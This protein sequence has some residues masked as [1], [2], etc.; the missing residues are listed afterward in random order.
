MDGSKE[1]KALLEQLGFCLPQA[2]RK[3]S[4]AQASTS[5]ET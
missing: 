1:R 4:D 3:A 2:L 5:I